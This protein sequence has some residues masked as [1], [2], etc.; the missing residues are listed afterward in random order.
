MR[1]SNR[2][3][4]ITVLVATLTVA[5]CSGAG[6]NRG[7]TTTVSQVQPIADGTW[8]AFVT[9]G[10]DETGEM[11]LGIDLAEM[12]TGEEA[13]TAA[14]EDGEIAEGEDLPND[15]YIDNDEQVLELLHVAGD[16][17]FAL[18]S[19][20]DTSEKILVDAPIFAEV[21]EG[22]YS[23]EPL[24]GVPSGTPIAMEVT[25]TDGLVSGGDAVYLP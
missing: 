22:T 3:L 6:S 1:N 24:Y 21:Y 10:E 11:T 16:A 14:I 8:F 25:I 19:G 9:V 20:S 18:I 23:G 5:G 7:S 15:F 12:L 4:S 2:R 13:R 17:Q